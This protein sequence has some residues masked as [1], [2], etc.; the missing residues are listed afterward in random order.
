MDGQ[1]EVGASEAGALTNSEYTADFKRGKRYKKLIK[2]LSSNKAK[3]DLLRYRLHT[4]LILAMLLLVH[5]VFFIVFLISLNSQQA[6]VREVDGCG[7]V[8]LYMQR[9]MVSSPGAQG[10]AQGE[11]LAVVALGRTWTARNVHPTAH[12]PSCPRPPYPSHVPAPTCPCL[13]IA[14]RTMDNLYKNRTNPGWYSWGKDRPRNG[15]NST[16]SADGYVYT[17]PAPP[18]SAPEPP[19]SLFNATGLLNATGNVTILNRTFA[20]K[21]VASYTGFGMPSTIDLIPG[22][23]MEV[24]GPGLRAALNPGPW[25]CPHLRH[26]GW[27][28]SRGMGGRA[29]LPRPTTAT[30][31]TT[32]STPCLTSTQARLNPPPAGDPGEA[33]RGHGH[34]GAAAPGPVPGLHQAALAG[35]AVRAGRHLGGQVGQRDAV[36]RHA[37]AALCGARRVVVAKGVG[38][39]GKGRRCFLPFTL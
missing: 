39:Q 38:G 17:P 21:R 30:T 20:S 9:I 28:G 10:P 6:Y 13:Q 24:R 25:S 5:L 27:A 2:L 15:T 22:Y 23:D 33:A 11:G 1:S 37:R 29:P 4:Y 8:S 35:R 26:G 7:L 14:A 16:V 3:A 19:L 34:D 12:A 36:H 31:T 32:T 18:P